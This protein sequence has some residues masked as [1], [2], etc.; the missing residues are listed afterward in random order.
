[1][2]KE[3]EVKRWDT[4]EIDR[5]P[6]EYRDMMKGSLSKRQLEILDGD[7]LKSSE[8]MIFG[9]MYSDWKKQKGYE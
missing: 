8:G 6:S 5:F 4:S 9:A 2:T 7:A 1:M 3:N